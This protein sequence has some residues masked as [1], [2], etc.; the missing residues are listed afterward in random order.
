MQRNVF[1]NCKRVECLLSISTKLKKK[2]LTSVLE[3]VAFFKSF[4]ILVFSFSYFNSAAEIS[5]FVH[6]DCFDIKF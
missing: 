1:H 6:N 5:S 3:S 2:T 4:V